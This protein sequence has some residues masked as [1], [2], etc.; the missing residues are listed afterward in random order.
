MTDYRLDVTR[1]DLPVHQTVPY[2]PA[3]QAPASPAPVPTGAA[4]VQTVQLPD[5]RIVSGYAVGQPPAEQP[6]QRAASP[7]AVNI[8]LGSVAFAAVCGGLALLTGFIAALAALLQQLIILAAVIFGGWIAVQLFG[9]S[10]S[11]SGVTVNAKKAVFKRN[12]FNG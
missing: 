12:T 10:R 6:Q 2:V 5:G 8:A 4:H 3:T 7:L 9:S 11:S 1:A